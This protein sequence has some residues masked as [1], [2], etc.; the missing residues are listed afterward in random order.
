MDKKIYIQPQTE[1]ELFELTNAL[2]GVSAPE[3]GIGYGGVDE[4][5]SGDPDVKGESWTDIW[6]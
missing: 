1:I 3:Q 6:E 5:G 4:D 2:L